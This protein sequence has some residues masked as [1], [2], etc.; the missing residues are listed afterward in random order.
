MEKSFGQFNK[1]PLS[2][3]CSAVNVPVNV[4]TVYETLKVV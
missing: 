2:S 3:L 4:S 1:I